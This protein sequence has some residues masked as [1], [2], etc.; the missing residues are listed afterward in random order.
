MMKR[1]HDDHNIDDLRNAN[2]INDIS[3]Q[4]NSNKKHKVDEP[5]TERVIEFICPIGKS[6]IDEEERISIELNGFKHY[7]NIN[8]LYTHIINDGKHRD[9]LTRIEYTKNQI[10]DIRIFARKIG[11]VF[12]D[13]W[14]V[15]KTEQRIKL[16]FEPL[17]SIVN[18]TDEN[19][20]LE[21]IDCFILTVIA[22][23]E[24]NTRELLISSSFDV[25]TKSLRIIKCCANAYSYSKWFAQ[26]TWKLY[27]LNRTNTT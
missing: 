16:L 23:L 3:E 12:V 11:T 1:K 4:G 22:E 27:H 2:D 15:I 14:L 21:T 6:L 10:R 9:P 19:N 5:D 7:Y 24:L 18:Y 17:L 26:E 13:S 20:L 8:N 25:S